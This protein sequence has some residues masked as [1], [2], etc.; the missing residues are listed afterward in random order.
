MED[1]TKNANMPLWCPL[2]E[3]PPYRYSN[4]QKLSVVCEVEREI[5]DEMLPYPLRP[6]EGENRVTV[7]IATA[8]QV[9]PIGAYAQCGIEVPCKFGDTQGGCV[10]YEGVTTEIAL[11]SGREIWGFPKKLVK[12]ELKKDNWRISGYAERENRRLFAVTSELDPEKKVETPKLYPRLLV[13]VIPRGDK[14]GVDS[15]SACPAL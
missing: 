8:E 10:V 14:L 7:Y 4:V 2:F 5:I 9:N 12:V 11:C 15:F 13:R 6:I 3:D 1:I